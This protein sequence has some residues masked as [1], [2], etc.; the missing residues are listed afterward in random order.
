MPRFNF[1]VCGRS[2]LFFELIICPTRGNN[3][4]EYVCVTSQVG[5]V[6]GKIHYKFKTVPK[7][8]EIGLALITK[9][10]D[11]NDGILDIQQKSC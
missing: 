5:P 11:K 9:T 10:R 2:E 8:L 4:R 7:T 3:P 1:A 6:L